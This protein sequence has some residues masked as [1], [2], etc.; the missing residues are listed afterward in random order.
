MKNLNS[1]NNI[2][3]SKKRKYFDFKNGDSFKFIKST[4]FLPRGLGRSYGDVCLNDSGHLVLMNN[5]K[6]LSNSIQKMVIWNVN[7]VF[8]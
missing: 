8:L 4:T 1:W 2:P 7:L 3:N 6:Q 5:H